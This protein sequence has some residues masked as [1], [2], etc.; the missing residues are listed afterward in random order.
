MERKYYKAI[1]FDLNTGQLKDVYPGMNYRKAY[2]DLRS[3]LENH[4]FLHRQG[5]GYF[6]EEK[7]S[8]AD[9]YDLMTDLS[10]EFPWLCQSVKKMDVTNIGNQYDL[11]ELLQ[12]LDWE[13]R[14]ENNE[15]SETLQVPPQ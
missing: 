10:T 4:E 9:I 2:A 13:F 1:N 11:V 14:V 5:S 3:F 8:T 7:L 12:P 15:K 6:S